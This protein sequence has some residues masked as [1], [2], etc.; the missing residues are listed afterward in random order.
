MELLLLELFEL[1]IVHEADST[2]KPFK[3]KILD[4]CFEDVVPFEGH[5][6]LLMEHE[7][8]LRLVLLELL[9]H[10]ARQSAPKNILIF[11]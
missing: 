7:V 3:L 10:F 8:K 5:H 1:V 2:V 9:V 6:H 4:G 11:C